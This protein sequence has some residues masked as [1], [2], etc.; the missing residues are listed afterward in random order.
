MP[1]VGQLNVLRIHSPTPP[2]QRTVLPTADDLSPYPVRYSPEASQRACLLGLLGS[3][4]LAANTDQHRQ[5]VHDLYA[6][7]L[8]CLL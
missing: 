8:W 6:L 7:L 1:P 2:A 4:K 3:A 5:I